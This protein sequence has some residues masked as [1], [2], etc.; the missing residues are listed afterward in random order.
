MVCVMAPG[1][2]SERHGFGSRRILHVCV[3]ASVCCARYECVKLACV[4]SRGVVCRSC[5]CCAACCSRMMLDVS[6]R[7]T[8]KGKALSVPNTINNFIRIPFWQKC[9]YE[10]VNQCLLTATFVRGSVCVGEGRN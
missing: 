6:L 9:T 8:R 10:H 4:R 5:A 1:A 2:Q 7:G 3:A